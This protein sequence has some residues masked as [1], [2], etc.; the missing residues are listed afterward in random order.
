M[1]LINGKHVNKDI[2]ILDLSV[3]QLT[4]LPAE[5]GQLTQ[6][7]RLDLYNNKLTQL[8]VEIGQLTQLKTLN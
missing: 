2:T 5:I 4:K 1:I 6:L 8:S 3:N 7:I